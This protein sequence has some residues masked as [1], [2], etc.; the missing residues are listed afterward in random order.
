MGHD[1]HLV[2][3]LK[4]HFI[5]YHVTDAVAEGEELLVLTSACAFRLLVAVDLYLRAENIIATHPLLDFLPLPFL[6]VGEVHG[7]VVDKHFL[8]ARHLQQGF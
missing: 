6:A 1:T 4:L 5:A 7:L 8:Y 2:D 3:W